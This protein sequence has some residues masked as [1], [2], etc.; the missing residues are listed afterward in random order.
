MK[1]LFSILAFLL[2]TQ[3]AHGRQ[4]LIFYAE[5]INP[6]P[7]N[8]ID[9][10]TYSG[11]VFVVF[12][13]ENLILRQTEM[14]NAWG[15]YPVRDTVDKQ[16]DNSIVRNILMGRDVPGVFKED[17]RTR[18]D[19]FFSI[20]VTEKEFSNALLVKNR[21]EN[22]QIPYNLYSSSCVNFA[23][24]IL[25]NIERV[26]QP[27]GLPT[28]P[29]LYLNRIKALNKNIEEESDKVLQD[30]FEANPPRQSMWLIRQGNPVSQSPIVGG[31]SSVEALGR[32]VIEAIKTNNKDLWI[33]CIHSKRLEKNSSYGGITFTKF[34]EI[35]RG[36]GVTNWN[37][38][39]FKQVFIKSEHSENPIRPDDFAV[40]YYIAHIKF[41][42]NDL[43]GDIGE[44]TI[45]S[46]PDG[47]YYLWHPGSSTD[48]TLLPTNF[49]QL[50]G[51]ATPEQL[52]QLLLKSLQ[53]NN[54]KLFINCI[55][56]HPVYGDQDRA[57]IAKAFQQMKDDFKASGVTN[58]QFTK[59]R[60]TA[61]Y[62]REFE[63]NGERYL[64]Q[65]KVEFTYNGPDLV[66]TIEAC[67]IGTYKNRYYVC[68]TPGA[69][70]HTIR[71]RR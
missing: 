68:C 1:K 64:P 37:L 43:E 41:M 61:Y 28:I 46:Q 60:R 71:Y 62:G 52:G 27:Q 34:R 19:R 67:T 14:I 31:A 45:A 66:G 63:R 33:K 25:N 32:T 38:V 44:I 20:E 22:Q 57:R 50:G 10:P 49:S 36:D 5:D 42:Y 15:F 9:P 21:Y 69:V 65:F 29:T 70:F 59:F 40:T 54:K 7:D 4:W 24:D 23:R 3:I 2:F 55:H 53:T 39:V 17:W 48:I 13:K 56:P 47:N 51:G 11:H 16:N 35:L 6:H 58:W 30:S 18:R 26:S 12:V 8:T